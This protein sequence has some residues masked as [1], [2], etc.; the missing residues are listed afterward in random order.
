MSDMKLSQ[1]PEKLPYLSVHKGKLSTYHSDII[2]QVLREADNSSAAKR[3]CVNAL[4][5]VSYAVI[6]GDYMG[7]WDAD[8]PIQHITIIDDDECGDALGGMYVD[9]RRV[10]WDELDTVAFDKFQ[11]DLPSA[12]FDTTSYSESAVAQMTAVQNTPEPRRSSVKKS[13]PTKAEDASDRNTSSLNDTQYPEPTIRDKPEPVEVLETVD[14]VVV[15]PVVVDS[16]NLESYNPAKEYVLNPTPKEDLYLKPP[17][18]PQFYADKVWKSG[19]VDGSQLVIYVTKPEIPTKQNEISCTTDVSLMTSSDLMKLFPNHII[20][21]R[22]DVMYERVKGIEY[23]DALGLIIPIQGFTSKQVRD[24]IIK[25]PHLFKLS[26]VVDGQKVGFYKT[27]EIDGELHDTMEVWDSLVESKAMPLNAEFIKEYVIRRYLLER[28]IR[29]VEH[30]YPMFGTLDPFLTL[31]MPPEDYIKRGY[32]K[33]EDLVKQ[34][35]SAR[36]SYKQSR[37]PI[38]RRLGDA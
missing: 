2:A 36:V 10:N 25:Y 22:A 26:K 15:D 23:D 6:S 8:S 16:A 28:D 11:T 12:G 18:F 33:T 14:P 35:V 3:R 17:T 27:I 34:C 5:S 37:N 9:I 20:H 13:K 30:R 29:R 21:T 38:L 7:K 19:Y 32:K 31:F 1:I 4:N 24:N